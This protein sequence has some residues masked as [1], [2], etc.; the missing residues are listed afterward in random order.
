M[1][2]SGLQC[3]SIPSF[4]SFLNIFISLKLSE[5]SSHILNPTSNRYSHPTHVIYEDSKI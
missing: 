2:L 3:Y 1:E 4:L 5:V